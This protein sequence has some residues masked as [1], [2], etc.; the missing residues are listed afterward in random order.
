MNPIISLSDITPFDDEPRILDV[1]L[2]ERLG[3]ERDRN[4]RNIIER[5]QTELA[6]YGNLLHR[7]AKSRDLIGRGRPGRAY[8]LN[9]GQALVICAL[10]RTPA[11]ARVRRALIEVFMAFRR[12]EIVHVREHHRKLPTRRRAEMT[13]DMHAHFVGFFSAF[14]DQPEALADWAIEQ[15]R[16][17]AACL[18]DFAGYKAFGGF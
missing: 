5:N 18:N 12:G 13:F 1:T 16:A 14:R 11:A 3:F 9:E 2:A 15:F 4:I 7:E 10:S 6:D 8:Y 17:R